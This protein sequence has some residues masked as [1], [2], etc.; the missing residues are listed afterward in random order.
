MC[1]FP[2]RQTGNNSG[3]VLP[4]EAGGIKSVSIFYHCEEHDKIVRAKC[5]ER[6]LRPRRREE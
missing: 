4:W 5:V 6:E 2:M 1:I 3:K